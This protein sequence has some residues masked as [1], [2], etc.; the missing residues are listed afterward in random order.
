MTLDGAETEFE[1]ET[2]RGVAWAD[3]DLARRSFDGCTFLRCNLARANLRGTRFTDCTFKECDLSV[4][5]VNDCSFQEARFE[6]CKLVGVNWID[7][8]WPRRGGLN[9]LTFLRCILSHSTFA[10]LSLKRMT[11]KDC[12]AI[13]VVFSD[14]DLTETDCTG[15]DFSESRFFHTNLTKADFRGA[16][17]YSIAPDQN[18]LRK[19]RFSLPEAISLLHSLDIVLE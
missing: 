5:T 16:T 2:F 7:A 15:T 14:A 4:A 9:S 17:G 13:D 6:D 19:T 1:G 11:L 12:T 18:T 10:G 8:H 3:G